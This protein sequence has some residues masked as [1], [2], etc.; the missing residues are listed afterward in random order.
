MCIGPP[1]LSIT[2]FS[3]WVTLL[4][5][6]PVNIIKTFWENVSLIP[7]LSNHKNKYFSGQKLAYNKFMNLLSCICYNCVNIYNHLTSKYLHEQI[8]FFF[9]YS[10]ELAVRNYL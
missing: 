4:I 1:S 5:V 8:F 3:F 6:L 2:P 10:E 9:K 7:L